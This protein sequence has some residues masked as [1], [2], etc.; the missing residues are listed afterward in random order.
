MNKFTIILFALTT[1]LFTQCEV[2]KEG[3]MDP[4]ASNYDVAADI[5]DGSCSYEK[6]YND[7]NCQPHFD[8]NL[9]ITNETNEILILYAVDETTEGDDK[10]TC[11]PSD[12]ENFVVFIPNQQNG[13][14]RLQV[15]KAANVKNEKSPDI[16]N[17]YR[18]WSVALS[19]STA[20]EER[21]NWVITDN[22][23]NNSSGTLIMSYPENDEYNQEVIY[24]VD[25]YLNSKTGSRLASLQPGATDKQVS[26]DYGAHNLHFKYW[27]SDPNSTTGEITEIGWS[28]VEGVVI[29][30]EHESAKLSIPVY[31]SAVGKYGELTVTNTTSNAISIY[32][33]DLLI[34]DIAQ[35]DGSSDGLS[36]IPANNSTTF[37]IPEKSYTITAKALNG[38]TEII[39]YKG[40]NI[41]QAETTVLNIGIKHKEISIVNNTT[42]Q[43]LLYNESGD[44]LGKSIAAGSSSGTYLVDNEYDS[45]LVITPDKSKKKKIAATTNVT[46]S[47]LEAY[48]TE[49]LTIIE[50]WTEL[51]EN[52]YRSPEI[53]H[54]EVTSMTA[55]LINT[56]TILLSF[57]YMVSSEYNFD[58]FSFWVDGEVKIEGESGTEGGWQNYSINIAPGTHTVKWQ[59]AKD[60]MFSAG[61]DKVEVKNITLN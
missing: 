6:N 56:S 51:G 45:V 3:C 25:V 47:S 33:D 41:I 24:Q 13:I 8:G 55:T 39:S 30:A 28:M 11:I 21:A 46:V 17:V 7:G 38:S 36:I 57:E 19:N 43:L 50:H 18:Q 52:S 22:D 12:A 60:D 29:N 40:V 32:A 2:Y 5:D 61:E 14:K 27:Y 35:I 26:I 16:N 44:Y 34:E 48:I 54:R 58:K 1:V 31:Y 49:D 20:I 37:V 53:S 10:I 15:W 4:Y 9:T 23:V 59:Y 42:E